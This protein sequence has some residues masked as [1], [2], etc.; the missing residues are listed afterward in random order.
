MIQNSDFMAINPK[1]KLNLRE[2]LNHIR[3]KY[4][5]Y[6][7]LQIVDNQCI[8]FAGK[9]YNCLIF[10]MSKNNFNKTL[11]KNR[12]NLRENNCPNVL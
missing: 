11:T 8:K 9:P 5:F 10:I 4:F 12:Q 6:I 1:K 3:N 7:F 2:T